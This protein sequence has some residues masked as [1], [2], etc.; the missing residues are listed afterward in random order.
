[1]VSD[2]GGAILLKEEDIDAEVLAKT[3]A[4]ML[5]NEDELV[6]MGENARAVSFPNATQNIVQ[7][8]LKLVA[9]TRNL[10]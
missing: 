6:Q 2:N 9:S 3:I 5:K 7:E 8:S 4:G 1:M 10:A